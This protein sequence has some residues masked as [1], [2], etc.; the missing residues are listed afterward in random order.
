MRS[1]SNQ[2]RA[3]RIEQNFGS[4][5]PFEANPNSWFDVIHVRGLR[6]NIN[7]SS[8]QCKSNSICNVRQTWNSH[9]IKRLSSLSYDLQ[10]NPLKNR[11]RSITLCVI[12]L[13]R[14]GKTLHV[15]CTISHDSM[16]FS[17]FFPMKIRGIVITLEMD[18]V[19]QVNVFQNKKKCKK[20]FG[21]KST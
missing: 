14:A 1:N 21:H 18:Y 20:K 11:K 3:N 19:Q 12:E 7:H 16:W 15:N 2:I 6:I 8:D 4:E 13:Y 9:E 17:H 10:E 5:Y